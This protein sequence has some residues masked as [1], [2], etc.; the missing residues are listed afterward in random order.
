MTNDELIHYTPTEADKNT[1]LSVIGW[2]LREYGNWLTAI[3]AGGSSGDSMNM[4][5]DAVLGMIQVAWDRYT[6]RVGRG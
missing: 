6:E 1:A 5:T 3:R 2:A 4:K